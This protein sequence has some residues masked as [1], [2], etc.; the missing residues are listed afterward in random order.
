MLASYA[1]LVAVIAL[2]PVPPSLFKKWMSSVFT[3]HLSVKGDRSDRFM[4][5]WNTSVNLYDL[6]LREKLLNMF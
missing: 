5:Q 3:S 6:S 1:F 2:L 4:T